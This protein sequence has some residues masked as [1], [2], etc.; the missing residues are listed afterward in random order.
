MDRLIHDMLS[1][2]LESDAELEIAV[3]EFDLTNF[4]E[5][6]GAV[7]YASIMDLFDRMS[8]L[9]RANLILTQPSFE[10]VKI[11]LSP[12]DIHRLKTQTYRTW[13]SKHPSIA[14]EPC[15]VCLE[16]F[17]PDV[18]VKVLPC[19]HIFH[20]CCID[21]WLE[22]ESHHCPLCRKEVGNGVPKI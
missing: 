14:K 6:T 15:S 8:L 7:Q 18:I 4:V 1:S 17:E 9:A 20:T 22:N 10:D 19:D 3:D 2:L 13:E 16:E 11:V 21:P 5:F 12:E